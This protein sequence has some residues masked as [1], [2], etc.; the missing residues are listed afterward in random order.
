MGVLTDEGTAFA[1]DLFLRLAE[2]GLL[3]LEP[4]EAERVVA[5]L[6]TTLDEVAARLYRLEL[7]RKLRDSGCPM[8]EEVDRLAVDAVFEGQVAA[9]R[10]ERAMVELPK[11]IE[12]FRAA[13]RTR[14]PCS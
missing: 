13:A 9:E 3:V 11:Y 14:P 5:S 10:W 6:R 2:Q 7:S 1:G 12:A 4:D 8:T